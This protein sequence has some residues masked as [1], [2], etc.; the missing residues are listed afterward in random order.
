[1]NF[2]FNQFLKSALVVVFI[3]LTI[4]TNAQSAYEGIRYQAILRDG[5]GSV[6]SGQNVSLRMTIYQKGDLLNG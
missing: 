2:N 5:S 4:D 1:M 3:W 6:I